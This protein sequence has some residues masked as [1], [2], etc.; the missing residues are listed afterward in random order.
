MAQLYI[1]RSV[2]LE[3]PKMKPKLLISQRRELRPREIKGQNN[4][5]WPPAL[6]ILTEGSTRPGERLAS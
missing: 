3:G 5:T 4:E 2:E 6:Q 1:Q